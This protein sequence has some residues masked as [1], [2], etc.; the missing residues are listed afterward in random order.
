MSDSR[1]ILAGLVKVKASAVSM[2]MYYSTVTEDRGAKL[3]LLALKCSRKCKNP[4]PR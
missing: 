2:E 3:R 1:R 4:K